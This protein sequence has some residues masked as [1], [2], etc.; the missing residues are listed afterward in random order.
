MRDD[1]PT[2]DPRLVESEERYRAVIEN[3]SDMIQSVRPD[4]SFEFVNRAWEQKLGFRFDELSDETIW[5]IIHPDEMQHC[6]VLFM[7]AMQ[8]ET[9]ENVRT[10]FLSKDGRAIPVEGSVTSRFVDGQIIATHAF[11]RDITEQ[12]RA[13]ELEERNARLE[14]EQ[15]NRYLE[16]MAALGKLSAGLSHELNNPAAAAQRASARLAESLAERDHAAREL[17]VCGV[18]GDQW[19]V[20]E[21]LVNDATDRS[22]I[23]LDP[24]EA[25][26]REEE[27]EQWLEAQSV[28]E[29]WSIAPVLVRA[30][31]GEAELARLAQL[32]PPE[33]LPAALRWIGGA[34]AIRDETDIVARSTHRISELVGAVKAYS[35]MDRA[36]MQEVDV[37]EGIDNTLVILDHRLKD[38]TIR[39]EFDRSLPTVRALGS[40]LNQVWT[41]IIDNAI[42]A[43]SSGGTIT[44][45]T[46]RGTDS[47][48]VEIQDDG[49]GIPEANVSR[50][51]EPFFTTKPQGSGTGLGLDIV[52]RIVTEEHRGTIEVEST[53]GNTVFR[54]TLPLSLNHA[55]DGGVTSS[56]R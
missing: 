19:T 43:I 42:D 4:G 33:Q 22:R 47:V 36:T 16:K 34:V 25:S 28:A 37:H 48:V 32:F 41:N 2:I 17:T 10:T 15:H 45:R 39:R 56:R 20:L 11:F 52:W 35:F 1:V 18:Q 49:C 14:R 54:V 3:A 7:R 40:G 5:S 9:L 51:F 44:I 23:E 55:D 30:G 8:G 46:R 26:R 31:V 53:P 29:A 13:Q 24:L 50:V 12:L 38:V 6:S 21:G 27:I